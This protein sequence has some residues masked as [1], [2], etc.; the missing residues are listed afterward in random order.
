MLEAASPFQLTVEHLRSAML[1]A[2]SEDAVSAPGGGHGEC[3]QVQC[4]QT[5]AGALPEAAGSTG[6]ALATLAHCTL[7][8]WCSM[9]K[10]R[11]GMGTA[12]S[13]WRYRSC[14]GGGARVHWYTTS[15]QSG[16]E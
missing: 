13:S 9:S 4:E 3:V 10:Q 11:V 8:H 12:C 6:R 5:G 2:S 16:N 15:K 7:A 14:S 1:E